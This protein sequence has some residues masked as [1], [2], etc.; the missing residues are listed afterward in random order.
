[1]VGSA[2]AVIL[3]LSSVP[4]TAP[5]LFLALAPKSSSTQK[6]ATT[7]APALL[8]SLVPILAPTSDPPPTSSLVPILTIVSTQHHH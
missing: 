7:S 8:T 5:I 4:E 2:F 3:T 1:M 6:L